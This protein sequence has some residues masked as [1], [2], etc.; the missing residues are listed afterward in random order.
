MLRHLV[1][2]DSELRDRL[3]AVSDRDAFVTAVV[4]VAAERGLQVTADDVA[5]ALGSARRR[6][7]ERWV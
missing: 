1:A 5:D 2:T 6:W 3:L 7:L 4:N